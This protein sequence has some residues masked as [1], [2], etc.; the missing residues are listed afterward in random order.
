MNQNKKKSQLFII[1]NRLKKNKMAVAAFV[2]IVLLIFSF[3]FAP[4]LTPYDYD[5]QN[6]R[7]AFMMPSLSHP[8]GTDNLGRDILTRVLYGGRISLFVALFG[9]IVGLLIGGFLGAT[10]GYFGGAYENVVMR[11]MDI[12]MAIPSMLLAIAISSALGQGIFNTTIAIGVGSVPLFARVTRS[13][14]MSVKD[15]EYIEASRAIGSKNKHIILKHVLPNSFASML[16]IFTLRLADNILVV[17]SLTF[18]GLGVQPPTPEWGSMISSGRQYMREFF[19]IVVF[20]GIAIMITLIAFN[21][22]GDGLRD[23]LDPRL[24][25]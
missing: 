4:I 3:I 20:P 17:S 6:L 11:M 22:L 19:P 9:V 25:Q 16:V 12:L 18:L 14:V 5:Q 21:L 15:Q 23:A 24:K 13:A 1:W 7:E 10:A 2:I 8:F